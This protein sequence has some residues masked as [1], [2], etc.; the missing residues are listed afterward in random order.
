MARAWFETRTKRY[1][2]TAAST[3]ALFSI[4]KGQAVLAIFAR[5]DVA[6]VAGTSVTVGDGSDVDG[7]FTET[8]LASTAAGRKAGAGAYLAASGGKIYNAADT[9]DAVLTGTPT[10]MPD[11][12]FEILILNTSLK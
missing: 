11:I 5:V 1:K 8:E 9:V 7:L 10:T 12:V 2:P 6:R 4:A 3:T